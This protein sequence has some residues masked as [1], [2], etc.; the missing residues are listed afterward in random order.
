ME[1]FE[2]KDKIMDLIDELTVDLSRGDYQS[3]LNDIDDD[4]NDRLNALEEDDE[5]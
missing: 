3:V 2:I 4:I 1:T 5:N